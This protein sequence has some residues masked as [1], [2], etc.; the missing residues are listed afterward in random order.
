[1]YIDRGLGLESFYKK[2]KLPSQSC[3]QQKFENLYLIFAA[4]WRCYYKNNIIE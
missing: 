1:M 3:S 2:K 4:A